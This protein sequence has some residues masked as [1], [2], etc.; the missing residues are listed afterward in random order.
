MSFCASRC[1]TTCTNVV[2]I[3]KSRSVESGTFQFPVFFRVERTTTKTAVAVGILTV[4]H[5]PTCEY[6]HCMQL[7]MTTSLNND[8]YCGATTVPGI[9]HDAPVDYS[10]TYASNSLVLPSVYLELEDHTITVINIT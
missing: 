8:C 2:A 6:V 3:L 4:E 1:V 7:I 10:S 5:V 9:M